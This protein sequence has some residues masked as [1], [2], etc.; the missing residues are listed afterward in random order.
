MKINVLD[1]LILSPRVLS[2][3][4][5]LPS[6]VLQC[7]FSANTCIKSQEDR[8]IRF[9]GLSLARLYTISFPQTESSPPAQ[10]SRDH[11]NPEAVSRSC[12]HPG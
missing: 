5:F 4:Y 7:S 9:R 8:N 3:V 2:S 6:M 11:S 1:F 12:H 10:E